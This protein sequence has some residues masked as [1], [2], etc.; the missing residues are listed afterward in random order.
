VCNTS[1]IMGPCY[2]GC[3]DTLGAWWPGDGDTHCGRDTGDSC[4]NCTLLPTGDCEEGLCTY[5]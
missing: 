4:E 3:F 1:K 2:N 5:E